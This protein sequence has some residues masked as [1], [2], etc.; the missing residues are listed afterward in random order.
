MDVVVISAAWAIRVLC[1]AV[2]TAVAVVVSSTQWHFLLPFSFALPACNRSHISMV[3]FLLSLGSNPNQR[4]KD[5]ESCLHLAAYQGM[6]SVVEVLLEWGALT[7]M[8]NS[9]GE[10]PLF[11]AS[12]RGH[13]EV[14]KLLVQVCMCS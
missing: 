6:V 11:Y 14:A 9:Y 5:G 1:V 13:Y 3:K 8:V 4:N 10:T 12:R 7:G 2:I